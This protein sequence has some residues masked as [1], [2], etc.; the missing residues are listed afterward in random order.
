[1]EKSLQSSVSAMRVCLSNLFLRKNEG[2][3]VVIQ[4]FSR[5]MDELTARSSGC[6]VD[7]REQ[8]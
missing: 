5:R 3:G 4:A 8:F 6:S 1:M 7:H 2:G